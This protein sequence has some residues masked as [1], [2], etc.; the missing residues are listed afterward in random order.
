M[1]K[2]FLKKCA[3]RY[4]SPLYVYDLNKLDKTFNDLK[5]SLPKK[6]KILY[7]IKANPT[8]PEDPDTNETLFFCNFVRFIICK[9]VI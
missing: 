3:E 7:S 5:K 1:N 9:A 2:S 6:S 4:G 8:P